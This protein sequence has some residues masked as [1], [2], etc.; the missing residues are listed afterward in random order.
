[1]YHFVLVSVSFGFSSSFHVLLAF[2][3]IPVKMRQMP[4]WWTIGVKSMPMVLET[5]R[6]GANGLQKSSDVGIDQGREGGN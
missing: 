6:W 4:K 5:G 1:M 2:Q 3:K